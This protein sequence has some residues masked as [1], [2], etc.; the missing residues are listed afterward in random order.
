M[1]SNSTMKQIVIGA[2]SALVALALAGFWSWASDGG[3]VDVMGGVTKS[4]FGNRDEKS[5]GSN[6]K[7]D[8]DWIRLPKDCD[9]RVINTKF[10]K[11]PRFITAYYKINH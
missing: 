11:L 10:S 8:T 1:I 4:Q 5:I 3:L 2:A 9:T 7:F 6:G